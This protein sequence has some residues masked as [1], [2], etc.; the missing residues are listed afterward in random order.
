M[1]NESLVI[2]RDVPVIITEWFRYN[3]RGKKRKTKLRK[4]YGDVPCGYLNDV[5]KKLE[6]VVN[7]RGNAYAN[8]R[9]K[10]FWKNK[11]KIAKENTMG[12]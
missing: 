11:K 3:R 6:P 10:R 5:T 8:R 12:S 4:T 2:Y 7:H 9:A 1:K